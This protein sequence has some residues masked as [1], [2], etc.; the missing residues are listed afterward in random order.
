MNEK[1]SQQK[2]VVK[3]NSEA[4]FLIAEMVVVVTIIAVVSIIAVM[5]FSTQKMYEA[6]S[7][8]LQ[9]ID[10]YQEARQRSLS[11]RVTMRVEINATKRAVRLIDEKV[12]GDASDDEVIKTTAFMDQGVFIGSKPSNVSNAPTE[13]S[14]VPESA[15][16]TSNHPLSN[17]DSVFS[18][19]FQRNG[20]V[21]N[22]GTNGAGANSVP[23]GATIY[24]WS[25]HVNDNTAT[26][27]NAQVMRGITVLA[28]SGSSKM[29]K[30]LFD[31]ATCSSWTK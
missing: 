17:G 2:T 30:C 28:S 4:G 10:F 1:N 16:T 5:S 25:K 7:Q 12:P 24:V 23:T 11:Q 14:P 29:W 9:I 31:G 3:R 15:F 19:R 6:E 22:A 18:L 26:P 8:T 13:L 27:V 20:T 21:H